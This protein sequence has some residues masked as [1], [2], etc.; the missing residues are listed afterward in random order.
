[1]AKAVIKNPEKFHAKVQRL[2]R[3]KRL[4]QL[5]PSIY[6]VEGFHGCYRVHKLENGGWA[7]TCPGFKADGICTH[8][9]AV[10]KI[11]F[12]RKQACIKPLQEGCRGMGYDWKQGR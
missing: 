11:D 8:T 6:I 2:I 4:F 1:M 12:M 9:Q 5:C 10:S 3:E 7:C